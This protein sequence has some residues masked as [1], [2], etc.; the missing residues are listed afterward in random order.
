MHLI[1]FKHNQAKRQTP[2]QMEA[3]GQ[4]LNIDLT[5]QQE[6]MLEQDLLISN[7]N[8]LTTGKD[9]YL[10]DRYGYN[11]DIFWSVELPK[12]LE[13]TKHSAEHLEEAVSDMSESMKAGTLVMKLN[14]AWGQKYLQISD[15]KGSFRHA[16]DILLEFLQ[17]IQI[18]CQVEQHIHEDK[19]IEREE[20]KLSL[21]EDISALSKELELI[22]S[23]N[24]SETVT[25]ISKTESYE[26]I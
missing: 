18:D 15:I 3:K 4:G 19:R 1:L 22:R 8:S 26:K 20:E 6:E 5:T 2:E 21:N 24:K 23:Q 11:D 25:L 10:I 12:A 14:G 16:H 17:E 7:F 13:R 9:K